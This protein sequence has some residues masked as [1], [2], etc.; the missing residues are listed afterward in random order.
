MAAPGSLSDGELV[1]RMAAGDEEAFSVLYWRCH[2]S[3]YRF[4][5]RMSGSPAV[6]EE[7]TQ[8]VFLFLIRSS[9][10]YDAA[11]GP[12]VAFLLGVARNHVRRCLEREQ[13][14][15]PLDEFPGEAEP[16]VE[17]Q[18]VLGDLTK[19][20]S[21][22][23]VRRAV[24]ALPADYREVVVLCDL[25]EIDYAAAARILGC[26]LGTVRSRLHRARAMLLAKLRAARCSV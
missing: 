25:D 12:L 1:R 9:R 18:D 21:I 17:A 15:L 11:R 22:E 20:E 2:A 3:V 7:V 8:E 19:R 14:F 13:A 4:A 24:L 23:A 5:L 16:A 26:P 6:A 10:A